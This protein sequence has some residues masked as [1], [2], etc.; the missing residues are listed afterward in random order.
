VN[1]VRRVRRIYILSNFIAGLTTKTA[2]IHQ[3][4]SQ[5]AVQRDMGE[6]DVGGGSGGKAKKES[7]R[8]HD[9]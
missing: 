8:L 6:D 2:M 1:G 9:S 5:V 3:W 4:V 7:G